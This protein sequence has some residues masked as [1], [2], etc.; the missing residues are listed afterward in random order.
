MNKELVSKIITIY[1]FVDR[2]I[3]ELYDKEDFLDNHLKGDNLETTY[4]NATSVT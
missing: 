4:A 2:Q 3:R 1:L